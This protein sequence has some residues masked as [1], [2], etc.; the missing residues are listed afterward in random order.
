MSGNGN[1]N[2]TITTKKMTPSQQFRRKARGVE[3]NRNVTK[4]AKKFNIAPIREEEKVG[5]VLSGE[6][7][8]W[9]PWDEFAVKMIAYME[10]LVCEAEKK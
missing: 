5:I 4:L 8:E 2:K 6:S 1:G 7:G 3:H 9:Y 10:K